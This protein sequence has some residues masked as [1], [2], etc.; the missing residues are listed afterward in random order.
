MEPADPHPLIQA[1]IVILF[2]LA[3]ALVL[4]GYCH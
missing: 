1:V 2:T 3:F 4:F